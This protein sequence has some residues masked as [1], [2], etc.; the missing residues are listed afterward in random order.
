LSKKEIV[1]TIAQKND[2]DMRTI[3][4]SY[5]LLEQLVNEENIF[6]DPRFSFAMV[7]RMIGVGKDDLDAVLR[8]EVGLDGDGLFSAL[9]AGFLTHLGGKYGLKCFFQEL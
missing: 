2:T 9:R 7:C 5:S 3:E 4:E 1:R 8:K 6:L